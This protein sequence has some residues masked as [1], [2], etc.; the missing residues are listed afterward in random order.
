MTA[1]NV[2]TAAVLVAALWAIICRL[3]AM[4]QGVTEPTVFRQH[5]VLGMGLAA[6]LVLPAPLAK[7][8]LALAVLC[9]LLMAAPRWRD[10]AP[11]GTRTDHG[12]LDEV[13]EPALGRVVGR[14]SGPSSAPPGGWHADRRR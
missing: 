9:W 12:D 11:D 10:G 7:F 1:M 5:F 3:N 2:I 4:Q 6:A 13:P 14:Q 8:A